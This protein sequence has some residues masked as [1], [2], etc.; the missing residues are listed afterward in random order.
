MFTNSHKDVHHDVVFSYVSGQQTT[1]V[2][3][4]V[5]ESR[6]GYIGLTYHGLSS[7]QAKKVTS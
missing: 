5:E 1:I 7:S 2:F 6:G 3:V 4:Y